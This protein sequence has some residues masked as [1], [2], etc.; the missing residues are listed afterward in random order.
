MAASELLIRTTS[1]ERKSVGVDRAIAG[2]PDG[3]IYVASYWD[4]LCMQ[5]RE[6]VAGDAAIGDT[7]TGR[8]SIATT[9]PDFLLRVPTGTVAIPSFV[10]LCQ[11]GTVAGGAITVIFEFDNADRYSSGGTSE[12]ILPARSDNPRTQACTFYSSSGSAITATDAAGKT[13]LHLLIGQDV[14]PAEGAVNGIYLSVRAGTLP[15]NYLVGPASYCIFT[16]AGTTGPT[17]GW[18]F[19][20]FELPSAEFPSG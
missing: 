7:V 13:V 14:S 19:G 5:G 8:T 15:V 12:G 3:A 10:N 9:T 18:A 4:Y 20:W 11:V 2:T 17:W 16:S 1:P 6:Y